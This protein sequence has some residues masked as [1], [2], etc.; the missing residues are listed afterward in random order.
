MLN[1]KKIVIGVTGS[2]AAYK[3]VYLV[4]E[5]K[6]A[7]ADVHVIMTKNAAEFVSPL[8]LK[9][10]SENQIF[11]DMFANQNTDVAHV[12]LQEDADIFVIAPATA[13]VIGKL[14][15]GVAD[16]FL[17]T[18]ALAVNAP[19]LI[20][21]SMNC[22]M[23]NNKIVQDN[24]DKLK[25]FGHSF[26][27]PESGELACNKNDI[28]RMSEPV[29][30]VEEIKCTLTKKPLAGK[31]VLVTAGPTV[32]GIDPVRHITNR[33]T[34][35]MGYAL[36]KAAKRA[37]A[38]VTLV[39]GPV[40]LP[41]PKGVDTIGV[42]NAK[43]MHETVM[44]FFEKSDIL[45]MAAACADFTVTD[46]SE[47]KIKKGD[48]TELTLNLK[49]TKDILSEAAN[50]KGSRIVVGFAAESENLVE[51]AVKKLR[52]KGL[53]FIVA[54]DITDVNAGFAVDTN[55]VSIIDSDESVTSHDVMTKDELSDVII[56]HI[57]RR[58]G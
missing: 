51:N 13:N 48:K 5:L 47:D 8:T 14:A 7:G 34:G 43:E 6:K 27:G 42:V 30:I 9:T 53:D 20:A 32:E 45:I 28:G 36:A 11:C 40:N 54:N 18:F 33:S 1:G 15:S 2:I 16:D 49:R 41:A 37:G 3:A 35:K 56:A 19:I 44:T 21:P 29:D 10:L 24:I 23:Y 52:E 4:R 50:Q 12:N 25:R 22:N 17:T 38:N 39:S 58:L 57:C 46:Y 31:N 26:I 55:V